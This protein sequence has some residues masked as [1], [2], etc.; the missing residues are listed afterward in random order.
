MDITREE[1][2]KLVNALVQGLSSNPAS[3]INAGDTYGQQAL[4]ASAFD[5]VGQGLA[6]RGISV[7]EPE[8]PQGPEG[9]Q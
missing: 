4:I 9:G 2:L 3:G 5:A 7:V 6:H 1:Y 8:V